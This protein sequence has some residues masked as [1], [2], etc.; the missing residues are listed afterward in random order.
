MGSMHRTRWILLTALVLTACSGGPTTSDD[1]SS[2]SPVTGEAGVTIDPDSS[3]PPS[4]SPLS[5]VTFRTGSATLTFGIH[6]LQLGRVATPTVWSPPPSQ[7]ALA[8]TS[9]NG[10]TFTLSGD[11]VAGT[12]TTSN[13]LMLA[14]SGDIGLRSVGDQC[15]VTIGTSTATSVDGT[16]SCASSG[17]DEPGVDGS[18]RAS[19]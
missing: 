10:T 7:V 19:T 4:G 6:E 11:V 2:R 1:G 16:F 12:Q 15:V 8:W 3:V 14:I 5:T 18:F 13:R 9:E 17:G